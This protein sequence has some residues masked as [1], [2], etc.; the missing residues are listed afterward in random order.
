MAKI[1][2]TKFRTIVEDIRDRQHGQVYECASRNTRTGESHIKIEG[3]SLKETFV[4]EFL[5]FITYAIEY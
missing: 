3:I 4:P 1:V 5:L 2:K